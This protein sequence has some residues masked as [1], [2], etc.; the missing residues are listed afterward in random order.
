MPKGFQEEQLG[1]WI[2]GCD[3]CQDACPFNRRHDWSQGKDFPGLNDFISLMQPENV[4][5]ASDEELVDICRRTANHLSEKDVDV[6]RASAGR[7]LRMK[8]KADKEE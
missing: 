2:V 3:V 8:L 7:A 1:T 6:L 4:L 5:A